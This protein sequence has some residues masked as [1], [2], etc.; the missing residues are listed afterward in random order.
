MKGRILLLTS[1]RAAEEK[2]WLESLKTAMPGE[3]I[4][5]R[6]QAGDMSD[7]E[8]A[9][10]ANPPKGV[11]A[12]LPGLKWVQSLWAG[13]DMLLADET[14]PLELPLVRLVDPML[15]RSMAE[16]VATHVLAL[17]R[18]LPLYAEQQRDG[19]WLQHDM[20]MASE[21]CVG[22]MGLGALGRAAVEMLL[23]V[24]FRVI[25]WSRSAKQVEGVETFS[26][27]DGVGAFLRQSEIL[28]NLLPLTDETRGI[29]DR[30]LFRQLPRGAQLINLARGAHLVE[31][32]LLDA[33]EDGTIGH[34]VLDVFATEPLPS[35]HPF[36]VNSR[37]TLSPHVAALTNQAS[38]SKIVAD[39][40]SHYRRDGT[41]PVTVDIERGY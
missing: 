30:A 39:N 18:R 15:S 37:I 7:I 14:Y 36:W 35:G 27:S 19:V 22:V 9:I 31:D 33:L 28:V 38:A 3:R 40:I 24:G 13:V 5:T 8:I 16:A 12:R 25:G 11:L 34:A 1:L 26:G 41:L 29:L 21:R 2:M 4:V 32:D 17:H 20:P 10:V 6:H 23:A